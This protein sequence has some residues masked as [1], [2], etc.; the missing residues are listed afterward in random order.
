MTEQKDG[1]GI[2]DWDQFY[3]DTEIEQM[4]WFHD[5]IDPDLEEALDSLGITG[6]NA[7]DVGTGPGTQA[8]ALAE[9]GLSVTATD[10]SE[11]AVKKAHLRAT[12]AGVE[13]DFRVDNILSSTLGEFYDVLFDRGC[14]H[15]LDPES[16]QEYVERVA[17]LLAPK[18]YLFLKCFSHLETMEEGPF[19][20]SPEEIRGYFGKEFEVVSIK[21][22]VYHGTLD[23][24]PKALFSVLRRK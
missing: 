7:L 17:G 11:S 19:R 10:L 5:A 16:R 24:E 4:P 8:I 2:E 3:R 21:E 13:I 12:G 9:R 23:P 18:G 15:T 6:G 1:R 14:F 22:T 20:F